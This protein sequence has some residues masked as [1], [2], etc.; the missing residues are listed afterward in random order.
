[1]HRFAQFNFSGDDEFEPFYD[2][3]RLKLLV[4]NWSMKD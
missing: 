1:M 3:F 4:F 2:T